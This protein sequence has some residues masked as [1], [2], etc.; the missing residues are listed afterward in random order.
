VLIGLTRCGLRRRRPGTPSGRAAAAAL[1]R[2]ALVAGAVAGV[3]LT[4]CQSK[5]AINR[6]PHD[7]ATTAAVAADG[8]QTVV[9]D[10]DSKYRFTPSTITVHPGK[11]RIELKHLGTSGAPHD[12]QLQGLPAAY[13]PLTS[14]GETKSVQFVAPAP[15]TYAFSCTIHVAQGMTGTLVVLAQ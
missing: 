15:G 5:S 11:V 4:G 2:T 6:E 7:G 1:L 10:T 8:V 13:V 14:A 12:W 9:L 3:A